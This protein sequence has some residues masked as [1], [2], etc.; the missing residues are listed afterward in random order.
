[1]KISHNIRTIFLFA[2][3]VF[4]VTLL[5]NSRALAVSRLEIDP[6][7]TGSSPADLRV[8]TD[9]LYN[10]QKSYV[11]AVRG[12]EAWDIQ[13]GAASTIIAV[14]DT[15]V[16]CSH[17]DL[18]TKMWQNPGETPNNGI[19]DDNNGFIDDV[20][21]Y[22]FAGAATGGEGEDEDLP[23]DSNP[24]ITANDPSVGNGLDDN[25]DGFADPAVTHGTMVAGIIAAAAN[26]GMGI[27]GMCWGCRIMAVRVADAELGGQINDMAEGIRYAARNG[28]KVI[29][30]SIGFPPGAAKPQEDANM[31]SA[32]RE[33]TETFGAVIVAAGGN[34]NK[35]TVREPGAYASTIAVGGSNLA[36]PSGRWSNGTGMAGSSWGPEIDV[37]A[38]AV[39]IYSTVVCSQA[40][41][42]QQVQDCTA[43]G[44]AKYGTDTGTSFAA[45]IIS[46]IVGLMLSQNPALTPAEVS[47][48]LKGT[49]RPL[50][51]DPSDNPDA[52]AAW[53][54]AGL[55]DAFRAVA[56][57]T[58]AT[59]LTPA[60]GAVLNRLGTTLTW[61][62]PPGTTQY[63]IRITPANDDGPGINLI[64]IP[65]TSYEVL[66]PVFGVGNY[67]ILPGMTYTWKIR[68]SSKTTSAPE[69]DPS[70][71]VWS[72]PRTFRTPAPSTSTISPVSP[73]DGSTTTGPR[74]TVR[75]DN[76]AKNIFYYE[77]Q[78][79]GDPTFN[80]D[81][82]TGT[83]FVFNLLWHAAESDPPNSYTAPPLPAGGSYYWRVKPRV[84]GDG[85]PVPWSQTW[86]FRIQD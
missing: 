86:S 53:A 1:M 77:V 46:G 26:N 75:W 65:E 5:T 67:V 39:A 23:G 59:L 64:R 32:V 82:A 19:D 78:M 81:P 3:A 31:K 51:N 41:V 22:D 79:S 35:G 49:A 43:P 4:S 6:V 84:Q 30:L 71:G 29:N 24:C 27:S 83:S 7:R 68:A 50:G 56:S 54:G 60:Q 61:G 18:Q 76:S 63:H 2:L 55:V 15:G 8:P 85:T 62:N 69:D 12:T 66:E 45:P 10:N 33:A 16:M 57:V 34:D 38:P 44:V 48:Y 20:F 14:V 25:G 74:V 36:Q 80:S 72:Q 21:G 9:P 52:G 40:D 13:T 28:A 11:E 73:A 37:V 17:P 58:P 70:W 47:A 42:N